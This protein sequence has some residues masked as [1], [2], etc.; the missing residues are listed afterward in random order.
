MGI[1]FV[2]GKVA[3]I[4]QADNG[5]L[6]LHH[7]NIEGGG[8]VEKTEHDLVVLSVGMLPNQEALSLLSSGELEED[9]HHYV[10]EVDEDHSPART[11]IEGVYAAGSSSAVTD[12]PDT[13]LHSGAAAA[14]A[15]A[16]VERVKK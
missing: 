15:A 10:K 14:L 11:S 4:D 9:S 5:N 3:K 2:K 8:K 1:Y 13:I 12:I 16:H 7:E 6:I